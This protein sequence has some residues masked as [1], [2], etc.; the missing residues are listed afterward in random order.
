MEH[1]LL[2]FSKWYLAIYLMTQSKTN[3]AALSLMRHLGVSWKTAWLLKHKPMEVMRERE[4]GCPLQDGVRVDDAYLGGE[5]TGGG[6]GRGSLNKVTFLAAVEMRNG[7]P[8]RVCF[9]PVTGFSFAALAVWAR[10]AIVPGSCVISDGLLGFEVL[11][12]LG[13]AHKVV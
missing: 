8:Q 1:S 2:P 10:Q 6:R 12:Q 5:L 7:R 11:G 9:D 13:Y 3:I 4:D